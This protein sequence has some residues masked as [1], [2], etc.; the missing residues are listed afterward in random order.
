MIIYMYDIL[1][2][3]NRMLC[4]EDFLVRIENIAKE[5][6]RGIILREKDLSEK[7]YEVLAK[8]V[9]AICKKHDTPCVLHSFVN[10]AKELE[11]TAIHLPLH[12]LRTL[13]STDKTAFTT[14]GASCHSVEE[15]AEAEAL[16]CTY[17]IAGHIFNTDC[18]RG[19]EGRGTD[20]LQDI[21]NSVSIPVYAIGGISPENISMVRAVKAAGACIMSGIMTCDNPAHYLASFERNKEADYEI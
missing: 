1:C 7:E 10:A 6:I 21:C 13:K 11:C 16:G 9:L 14:L 19:L 15:A 2:V 5:S 18:K 8:D 17:I 12:I 4:R 3:T 20:F